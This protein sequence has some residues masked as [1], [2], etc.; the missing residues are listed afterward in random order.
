MN[1][2]SRGCA[3]RSV[4]KLLLL[5]TALAAP[6]FAQDTAPAT[7]EAASSGDEEIVVTAQRRKEA[8]NSVGMAVQAFTGETLKELR[9]NNVQDL[10]TVAPSFSVSRSYQG[11]PI[12]TLRGIGFNTINLA[13]TST[14]GTYYD[15]VA[16]AFPFM[17]TGPIFDLQRV[18]VLKGPQGTL[19]GRNTTGGLID[20][21]TNKPSDEA[22]GSLTAEVGNFGTYNAEGYVTGA[23]AD[24]LQ[25]RLSFRTEDSTEGW[26]E[27]STR[28]GDKLG[29]VHRYGA[30]GE[31][32]WQA[33]DKL[34]FD[35]SLSGWI[36]KSDSLAGQ[37][38]GFT[39][40]TNPANGGATS[41]F[42]APGI[43]AFI[44][45]HNPGA[46]GLGDANWNNRTADWAPYAVRA[47][48]IGTGLGLPGPLREDNRFWAASLTTRYDIS[49]TLRFVALTGYQDLT[50]D[51]LFDWSGAPA[52]I[53]AQDA[54]GT[55]R[56]FSQEIRFEGESGAVNW[57]VGAYYG[58]DKVLDSNRTLLGDN[59][60]SNLLST[61]T[62]L[63]QIG[64]APAPFNIGF[65]FNPGGYTPAQSLAA[66]RTYEDIGNL[67]ADTW[68]VF[69]NADWQISDQFKVTAGL[70]YTED[71]H[72]FNGCSRDFNG[73][74]LPNVNTFNQLAFLLSQGKPLDLISQGECV[75]FH[76]D[77]ATFGEVRHTL[78][79]DNVAWRVV[80][81]WTPEEGILVYASISQGAK[82]GTTPINAANVSTQELPAKQEI[83]LAYEAGVKAKLAGGKVQLNASVFY[84]DYTDKQLSVYFKDPIYTA[85]AR[86][87]N[88]PESNAWGIDAD[89]T[90]RI[91]D[92]LTAIASA[93]YLNTE[94]VGYNGIN[95]AGQNQLYDGVSF[96]FSPKWQS[97]LTLTYNTP[98]NETLGFQMAINGRY[99]SKSASDLGDDP[100]FGI[101]AYGLLNASVGVYALDDKWRFSV[102]GRNLTDEYYWSSVSSNANLVV[103]FPGMPRTYGASLTFNF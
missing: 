6:A 97:S 45:G 67:D 20:F 16:Y 44:A 27:S 30:R 26:Q 2:S 69:G 83:L 84:Y 9:V 29:E 90:W 4:L 39:P 31:L 32:A 48:D 54:H 57:L 12:F 24:N 46:D 72:D 74:M 63:L 40:A 65:P 43:P 19:Y 86:L 79:E 66:F 62:Y 82:V 103:R 80:A 92:G 28:P 25:G 7:T 70:R 85:L 35:F 87:D 100:R 50:R 60:N 51:A 96:P 71:S 58:N 41:L 23:L 33:S 53:L 47:T 8:V 89:L 88:I 55:V 56:S 10:S 64:A 76:P 77:T 59:A 37:A 21:I 68:S 73:N 18:E 17:L 61:I 14:V 99:Q 13:A 52:N 42:N 11:V 94:I 91:T 36:N 93:T 78:T 15:E 95:A 75:T 34:T 5:S 101:K 22:A 102:W 81:N 3:A 38:I 1:M 98:I 49:D